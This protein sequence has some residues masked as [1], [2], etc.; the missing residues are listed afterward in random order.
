MGIFCI[1]F[2]QVDTGQDSH[3]LNFLELSEGLLQRGVDCK[4]L[5][6][7]KGP[8]PGELDRLRIE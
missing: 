1:P 2:R 8:L 7:E 5:V 4:I 6:P 3:F